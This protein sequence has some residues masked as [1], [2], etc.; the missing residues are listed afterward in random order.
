[1]AQTK[2]CYPT[3]K[4]A[5][6]SNNICITNIPL[7]FNREPI[8]TRNYDKLIGLPVIQ[9]YIDHL[10]KNNVHI[11]KEHD[12]TRQDFI[13]AFIKTID[14]YAREEALTYAHILKYNSN[15]K[16]ESCELNKKDTEEFYAL[17]YSNKALKKQLK[18]KNVK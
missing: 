9:N 11:I 15:Y 17:L 6:R 4:G 18:Q 7:R 16:I 10:I 13:T 12:L 8:I 1:M 5:V 2:K 3:L 14:A